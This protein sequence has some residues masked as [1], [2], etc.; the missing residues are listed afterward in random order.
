MFVNTVNLNMAGR[1]IITKKLIKSN[2][3]RKV[4]PFVQIIQEATGRQKEYLDNSCIFTRVIVN[5]NSA[6]TRTKL[7]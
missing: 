6:K 1:P 5:Y 7:I 4:K 3:T 2:G